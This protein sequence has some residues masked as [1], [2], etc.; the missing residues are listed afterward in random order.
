MVVAWAR[1]TPRRWTEVGGFQKYFGAS[2]DL[3]GDGLD[4]GGGE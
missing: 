3:T 4:V 1:V 2:V